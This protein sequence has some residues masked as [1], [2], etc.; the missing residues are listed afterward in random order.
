M[1]KALLITLLLVFVIDAVNAQSFYS[2][3]RDRSLMFSFGLGQSTYHG[4]LHDVLFDGF[5]A[6]PNA[7]IGLRKKLGSQL[8]LRLDLNWYQIAAADSLN[9]KIGERKNRF[10][11][12]DK[13]RPRN[14]SFRSNNLELS[15][16]VVFNLIPVNNSYTRR[17]LIN[18]YIFA[19][20]GLSSNNPKAL[21]EGEWVALRPLQTELIPYSGR[22]MVVPIGIGVR[23]KANQ[24]IDILIEGGRRFTRTD[25]LDDV[26]T[27]HVDITEFDVLFG[28]GSE[29]ARL[30][31]ALSDRGPEGGFQDF[32]L[33]DDRGN[34]LK[35]DS[36]Y[37]FQV[38]LE[39]YLPE[40]LLQQ[41]F[42]PSR[43]KPKF[44]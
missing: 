42:S 32:R 1:K 14:L 28:E 2:R 43:K 39:M 18:P 34:P 35:N 12:P 36:Y 37:I 6:R 19:G 9:Q 21:Y 24:Y 10:G 16:L 13:R 22:I 7:G 29:N 3:R 23:L 8:S 27:E 44:R 15:A 5:T 40:N 38:R 26:S 41:L 30:A 31:K 17:P 4:D 20:L 11:G 33:G 25:Y